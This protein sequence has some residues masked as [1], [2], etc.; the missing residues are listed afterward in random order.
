VG[1]RKAQQL[2]GY[3]RYYWYQCQAGQDPVPGLEGGLGQ[4]GAVNNDA[5]DRSKSDETGTAARVVGVLGPLPGCRMCRVEDG[6][7]EQLWEDFE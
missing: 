4:Q 7:D 5:N 3:R 2:K 6:L 1:G